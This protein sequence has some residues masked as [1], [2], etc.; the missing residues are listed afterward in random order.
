MSLSDRIAQARQKR[1]ISQQILADRVGVS[2]AAVAQ[3]ET[4]Q[5]SPATERLQTL[6]MVLGVKFEWLALGQGVMEPFGEGGS[7]QGY[8]AVPELLS[9][10]IKDGQIDLQFGEARLLPTRLIE[11]KLGGQGADFVVTATSG[12]QMDPLIPKDSTILV[13]RRKVSAGEPGPYLVW[14]GT[15]TIVQWVQP[16]PHSQP[17]K[18]RLSSENQRFAAYELP[19]DDIQVIGR[20]VWFARML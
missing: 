15:H 12:N 11:Q 1:G 17:P 8:V 5:T 9:A 13:D 4:G 10:T 16:V 14:D 6:A 19:L 18:V 2:R 7:L 20:V 3:W